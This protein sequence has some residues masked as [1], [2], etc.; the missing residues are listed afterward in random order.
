MSLTLSTLARN[1]AGNAIVDLFDAGSNNPNGYLELRSGV[2]PANPQAAATGTL[3]ATLAFSNPAYTSFTNGQ[4]QANPIAADESVAATGVCTW[5]RIYD[6][7]SNG[8]I[9]GSVTIT[10]GGGDIEFDSVNFI[11]GGTVRLSSLT[12]VMPE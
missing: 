10:S 6:C 11:Q 7:D 12:I 2:R 1:Q 9:D 5:F 3:L 8:V 4:A